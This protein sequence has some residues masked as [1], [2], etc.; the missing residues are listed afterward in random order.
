MLGLEN[1]MASY[2]EEDDDP[3]YQ[4]WLKSLPDLREG[5]D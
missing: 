4:A 1:F 2:G 5:K 3:E